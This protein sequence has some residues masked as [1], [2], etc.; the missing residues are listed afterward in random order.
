MQEAIKLEK[1][2]EAELVLLSG[3]LRGFLRRLTR[4]LVCFVG[5]LG[6]RA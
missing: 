5:L 4:I 2:L 3:Y 1:E 6:F